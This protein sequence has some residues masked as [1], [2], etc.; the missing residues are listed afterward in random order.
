M[1]LQ[2]ALKVNGKAR[3]SHWP[4]GVYIYASQNG[5]LWV[6][7]P[8]DKD[9]Q[10]QQANLEMLKD[11]W[12]PMSEPCAH[13]PNEYDLNLAVEGGPFDVSLG[14]FNIRKISNSKTSLFG[15]D[16]KHC[17]VKIKAK[18]WVEA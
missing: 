6:S 7:F 17:G 14:A 15:N 10:Q 12:F 4:E 11:D 13:E 18:E 3:M 16:C 2:E 1:T 9:N 8:G 5:N